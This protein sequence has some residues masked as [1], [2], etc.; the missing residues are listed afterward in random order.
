[1]PRVDGVLGRAAAEH[2]CWLRYC[3]ATIAPVLVLTLSSHG[4]SPFWLHV[5]RFAR[6]RFARMRHGKARAA[7]DLEIS[8]HRL[9]VGPGKSRR[10]NFRRIRSLGSF[11]LARRNFLPSAGQEVPCLGGGRNART[12]AK[13]GR[14]A[15]K[16]GGLRNALSCRTNWRITLSPASYDVFET[17]LGWEQAQPGPLHL[18]FVK[19]M[20][21]SAPLPVWSHGSLGHLRTP[22]VERRT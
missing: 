7:G 11:C 12:R 5:E 4:V 17:S 22:K 19:R 14:S 8:N 2:W 21:V 16:L 3:S 10:G 15:R 6:G 1:M 13:C 18:S 20:P 9:G